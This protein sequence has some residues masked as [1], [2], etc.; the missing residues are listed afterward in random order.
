MGKGGYHGGGTIIGWGAR[1]SDWREFPEPNPIGAGAES[2]SKRAQRRSQG[3]AKAA[4]NGKQEMQSPTRVSKLTQKQ[5]VAALGLSPK[6][7]KPSGRGE[8]LKRLVSEG[9]LLPTGQPNP[10]HPKVRAIEARMET[11]CD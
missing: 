4:K 10:E 7:A 6:R 5:L 11:K 9:I 8:I 2:L 1:W 3:R